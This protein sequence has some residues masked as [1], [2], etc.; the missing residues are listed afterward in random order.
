M[1]ERHLGALARVQRAVQVNGRA[2]VK[3]TGE[4]GG[5][6]VAPMY[7]ARC[8]VGAMAWP[9]PALRRC[10]DEEDDAT[11][12]KLNQAPRMPW[13]STLQLNVMAKDDNKRMLLSIVLSH[14]RRRAR[15]TEAAEHSRTR[16]GE[17]DD[18]GL[19]LL[20]GV[21]VLLMMFA[22]RQ[23]CFLGLERLASQDPR[24]R[25]TAGRTSPT[26]THPT[27]SLQVISHL[28]DFAL[29]AL[30]QDTKTLFERSAAAT[31]ALP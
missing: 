30:Q 14:P 8:Q 18:G 2:V 25:A 17:D 24:C 31:N 20:A 10:L 23:A 4:G 1:A 29:R 28:F 15:R 5:G 9:P 6:A 19:A 7:S 21:V 11:S 13:S 3:V 22:A 12:A 27:E 16:A 26:T